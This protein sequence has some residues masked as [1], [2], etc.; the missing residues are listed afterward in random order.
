[1][2]G[3]YVEGVLEYH[4]ITRADVTIQE[5]SH[6]LVSMVSEKTKRNGRGGSTRVMSADNVDIAPTSNHRM[7]LRVGRTVGHREW[8]VVSKKTPPP[9]EVHL[10][11]SVLE[12][13]Q[14]DDT[15]VAQFLAHFSEGEKVTCADLPFAQALDLRTGDEVD[16]FLELYGYW[17]GDGYLNINAKAIAF[18]PKKVNDWDYLDALFERLER[19]LPEITHETH[20]GG[21]QIAARPPILECNK[22]AGRAAAPRVGERQRLYHISKSEWFDYFYHEYGHK[23]VGG[24]NE[25]QK[26]L[27][28]T[29]PPDAEN[30]NST[31]LF[32]VLGLEAAGQS[33]F[34]AHSQGIAIC[35]WGSSC[36]QG[37]LKQW[38]DPHIFCAIP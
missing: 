14:A 19:V 32:L 26:R 38:Q 33:S 24:P 2:F 17:V 1:M 28:G 30:T 16:A 25:A 4:D 37:S 35:C 22:P 5:G 3:C 11:G 6:D 23:Y 7:L 20:R 36:S 27:D 21:V 34:A 12:K 29:Y 8:P 18:A 10:A 13:G 9:L 31:K 15:V